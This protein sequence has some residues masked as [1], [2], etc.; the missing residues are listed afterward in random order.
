MIN[1]HTVLLTR[2]NILSA[3]NEE[4]DQLKLQAEKEEL[5]MAAIQQDIDDYDQLYQEKGETGM[6][7]LTCPEQEIVNVKNEIEALKQQLSEE[8]KQKQNKGEYLALA[9]LINQL[10]PRSETT[11]YDKEETNPYIQINWSGW[12]GIGCD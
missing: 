4:L 7:W 10:P 11:K 2:K 3:I 9:K 6:T 8:K 1:A 5:V 12:K